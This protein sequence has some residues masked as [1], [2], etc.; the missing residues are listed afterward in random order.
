MSAFIGLRMQKSTALKFIVLLGIV[1]LFADMTYEGARSITGQ[2]LAVLGASGVVVGLVAGFGELIGYGLRVISG[3]I[4]DRTRKYWLITFIG[5]GIN[6]LAV[7]LLALAG[8]WPLAAALMIAERFGKAV[9][10]PA[11]DAMLSFATKQTGRGWGFGLHEALD[12]IGAILGPLIVSGVLYF[13][14]TY[15][16]SFALLLIPALC[17][18]IVLTAARI[19]YPHPQSME[20]E[21][22]VYRSPEKTFSKKFWIYIAA[23]SCVAAG[24]VDFPLIA[25]HFQKEAVVSEAWVP[26][27]FSIAM[28]A[29][30]LSALVFGK[31]YDS[32]GVGVL[33]AAVVLSAAFV[34]FVFIDGFYYSLFGLVLW[35][36][37]LGA[38]ESIMRAYVADLVPKD[39][40]GTAYGIM[41]MC[42]GGFWFLGST[43]TGYLYDNSLLGLIVFALGM[44]LISIPLFLAVRRTDD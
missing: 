12:Q 44:Q 21:K 8:N 41:N 31:L 13:Q 4:S 39:V 3:Y 33:I 18:L 2:Y 36:I 10:T 26:V 6:L 17:A 24:Y 38:Q 9:R 20:L 40:R 7:P 35:G 14:G 15:Q 16:M 11:R 23:I 30:G 1:S 22:Q 29:D 42:F 25:Y 32:K 5:Y 19:L 43:F 27:F 34:P 37:G 28:A